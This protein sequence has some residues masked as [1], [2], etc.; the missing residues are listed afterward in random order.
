MFPVEDEEAARDGRRCEL[1]Q[2]VLLIERGQLAAGRYE[3]ALRV[4]VR[5]L[6]RYPDDPKLLTTAGVVQSRL[7]QTQKARRMKTSGDS[8]ARAAGAER[9]AGFSSKC[10]PCPAMAVGR[11]ARIPMASGWGP[12]TGAERTASSV[13]AP[14]PSA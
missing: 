7:G 12:C 1:Q 6:D 3:E 13:G 5:A 11:E 9:S 10:T 2:Q 14:S 8:P 4:V